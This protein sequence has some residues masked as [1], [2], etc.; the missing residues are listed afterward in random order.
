MRYERGHGL[1]VDA[2]PGDD[3]LQAKARRVAAITAAEQWL[4]QHGHTPTEV[5]EMA[6][7]ARTRA[8]WWHDDHG[9]V[10]PGRVGA[11]MVL[12]VDVPINDAPPQVGRPPMIP[13]EGA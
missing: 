11:R 7:D 3:L 13:W 10:Q 4:L 9:F 12:I 1:I 2:D 5:I 8:A 6:L